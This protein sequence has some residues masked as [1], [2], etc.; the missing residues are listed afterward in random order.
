MYANQNRKYA[1]SE[2]GPIS[3][4]IFLFERPKLQIGFLFS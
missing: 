3:M 2:C 1:N 4:M